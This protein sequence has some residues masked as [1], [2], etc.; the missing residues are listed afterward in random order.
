MALSAGWLE[1]A[2]ARTAIRWRLGLPLGP[3]G[4]CGLCG[5][6]ALDSLGAHA[7]VCLGAGARTKLLHD[8][9]RDC[10]FGWCVAALCAPQRE[11]RPYPADPGRRID[12]VCRALGP[13]EVHVDFGFAARN[14]KA[15]EHAK[16]AKYGALASALGADLLPACAD[17]FGGWGPSGQSFLDRLSSAVRARAGGDGREEVARMHASVASAVALGVARVLLRAFAPATA[18]A[19]P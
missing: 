18:A 12:I 13:R 19:Q 11:D 17:L 8:A 6:F 14:A 16:R 15:Y 4:I 9:V 3:S 2:A 7:S 10:V 5:A 1:P